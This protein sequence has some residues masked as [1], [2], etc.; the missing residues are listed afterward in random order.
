MLWAYVGKLS[1]YSAKFC[2]VSQVYDITI[3]FFK[4][5]FKSCLESDTFVIKENIVTVQFKG[6]FSTWTLPLIQKIRLCY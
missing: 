5:Y 2:I 4:L 6:Q 3:Y 1:T